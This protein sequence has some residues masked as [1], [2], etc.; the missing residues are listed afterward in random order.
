MTAIVTLP[1]NTRT[2]TPTRSHKEQGDSES[3]KPSKGFCFLHFKQIKTLSIQT[4]SGKAF[5]FPACPCVTGNLLGAHSPTGRRDTHLC[6]AMQPSPILN[7]FTQTI[8]ELRWFLKMA[9]D[10]NHT[11]T[12][13][14]QQAS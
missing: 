14:F 11:D 10:W 13:T 12:K 1:P 3:Q 9:Q 4:V 7:S 6:P 2:Q 5:S 8:P